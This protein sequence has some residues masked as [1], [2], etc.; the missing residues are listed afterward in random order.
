MISDKRMLP[1]IPDL[2]CELAGVHV[3]PTIL[4]FCIDFHEP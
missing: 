4:I 1:P 2:V 3:Q